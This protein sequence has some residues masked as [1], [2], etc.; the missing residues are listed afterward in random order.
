M[1]PTATSVRAT[2]GEAPH[3][4]DWLTVDQDLMNQFG[5]AT[6]DP[7]WMH[8][9]PERAASDGPFDGTIAFGFWTLSLLSYFVRQATGREYPDGAHYGL[10]YGLDR[11]RL[12][13]PVPVGSRIRNRSVL[14]DVQDRGG[15]RFL[16]KTENQV[17]IEGEAKPAMVAEW[18]IMLFYRDE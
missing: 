11:V 10:N 6:L 7:D 13:A 9:D 4:S 5:A 14:V 12:L 1:K 8:L 17:E 16:L 2:W 3:I 15:G 18:L